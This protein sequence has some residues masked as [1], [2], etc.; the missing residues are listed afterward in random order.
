MIHPLAHTRW[1]RIFVRLLAFALL[2]STAIM[3]LSFRPTNSAVSEDWDGVPQTEATYWQ[4]WIL[5]QTQQAEDLPIEDI[6]AKSVSTESATQPIVKYTDVFFGST[7][8]WLTSSIDQHRTH[9]FQ[10]PSNCT[11]LLP[12]YYQLLYLYT[13]F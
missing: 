12:G 3:S 6:H 5:Q 11:L 2:V 4:W 1:Q 9:S 13:P 7:L 8:D 10:Y